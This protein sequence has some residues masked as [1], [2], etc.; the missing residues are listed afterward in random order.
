[1]VA[2]WRLVGS[3]SAVPPPD[4]LTKEIKQQLRQSFAE[5]GGKPPNVDEPTPEEVD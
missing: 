1:M 4:D 3:G 2:A 5:M